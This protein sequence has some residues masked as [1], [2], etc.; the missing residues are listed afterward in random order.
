MWT[1]P[2]Y[3]CLSHPPTALTTRVLAIS[4]SLAQAI[5]PVHGLS[6]GTIA[7]LPPKHPGHLECSYS[8]NGRAGSQLTGIDP[9]PG[10]LSLV[11]GNTTTQLLEWSAH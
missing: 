2:A 11:R 6:S 8:I 4:P 10:P 7:A 1:G 5:R 3:H 9:H